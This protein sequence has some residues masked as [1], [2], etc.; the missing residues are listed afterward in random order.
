MRFFEILLIVVDLVVLLSSFFPALPRQ[1]ALLPLAGLAVMLVQIFGEQPRWQML[2]LY[3][4]TVILCIAGLT[5]WRATGG[6]RPGW[7]IA[8][9]LALLLFS[10]PG[11]AFPVPNVP[12]PGGPYAVGTRTY[13]WVDENRAETLNPRQGV[14]GPVAGPAGKR[15]LLVQVWYP[16]VP[17]A[18][19]QQ[20]PFLSDLA[21]SGPAVAKAVGIPAFV[22][23]HLSLIHTHSYPDAPLIPASGAARFP[24]LVFSHGW[25][26]IRVQNTYQM[27]E[28]ASHGYVVFAPD[29]TYGAAVTTF[30]D[31][32][33]VLNRPE[34]LPKG[35]SDAEYDRSA[36]MVGQAWAGDLRFVVDQA[37]KLNAGSLTGPF[38]DRLDLTQVGYLGHSTGGGAAVEACATD[39]RCKAG[40][41]MDAWMV[42]YDHSL[43]QTG[44]KMPFFFFQ[45]E[46]WPNGPNASL[47]PALYDNSRSPVWRLTIAGS[48]HFD[49]SD[50]SLLTP[51]G[52]VLG[53]KGPIDGPRALK[54]V[55]AYTVAFF[56][57]TLRGQASQLLAG[58]A[59]AYPEIKFEKK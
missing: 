46:K 28:L 53:I 29:H 34:L 9:L 7:T 5:A 43:P 20:A 12:L 37:E 6:A 50:V 56:D 13:E 21:I 17:A 42:P 23:G 24:V 15:R 35:V 36:Q 1:A 39:P 32:T 14:E 52:S 38:K 47:T 51:L 18:G 31:G 58:A 59:P 33:V 10:L 11:I 3:A 8:G 54:M 48:K 49:F 4:L 16:A 25:K 44:L 2:P 30:G 27:E 40:F 55:N 19:A 22:L 26:G 45:S 57:Q 41:A